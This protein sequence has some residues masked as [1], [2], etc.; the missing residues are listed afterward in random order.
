MTVARKLAEICHSYGVAILGQVEFIKFNRGI[1]LDISVND[2]TVEDIRKIQAD[3]IS[4]AQ[5]LQFAG[6]DGLGYSFSLQSYAFYLF[7]CKILCKL[8]I[9]NIITKSKNNRQK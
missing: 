5:Q 2:L 8:I 4:A 3:I 9:F 1:D 6:F 7:F